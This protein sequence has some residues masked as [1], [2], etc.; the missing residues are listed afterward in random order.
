M[1]PFERAEVWRPIPGF[2]SYEA[3]SIGRI[4]GLKGIRK[5][6]R[7]P[8]GYLRV[9]LLGKTSGVHRFVLL[10]FIDKSDLHTN[11]KNGVK[12]DNRIENLEYVTQAENNR[13]ASKTGLNVAEHG[14]KCQ[15]SRLTTERA[16]EI[17]Y[18]SLPG[19]EIAKKFGVHKSTVYHIRRGRTW[20]HI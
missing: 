4:R 12:D 15:F 17:K 6:S 7:T 10:A 13:H 1:T 16:I 19:H 8:K 14:E 11:H 5:A 2:E 3:S 20:T 9:S 18:S